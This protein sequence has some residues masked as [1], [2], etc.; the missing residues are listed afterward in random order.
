MMLKNEFEFAYRGIV[1]DAASGEEFSIGEDRQWECVE[2]THKA[3]QA[4][5][6]L[7]LIRFEGWYGAKYT[8]DMPVTAD[9]NATTIGK[10]LMADYVKR[11]GPKSDKPR[12]QLDVRKAQ[13]FN[14][15][16]SV[17]KTAYKEATKSGLT[18]MVRAR[19]LN[20]V[21]ATLVSGGYSADEVRAAVVEAYPSLAGARPAQ[22]EV[23][24]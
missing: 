10:K 3:L 20:Q 13:A 23:K 7:I 8:T 9:G 6:S 12:V 18:S 16:S 2:S 19:L 22:Q 24:K 17:A 14:V 11:H 1:K 5:P 4:D 21:F 15:L